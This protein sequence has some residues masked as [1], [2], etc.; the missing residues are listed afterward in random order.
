MKVAEFVNEFKNK[1]IMNT[2]I[3]EHAVSDYIENTLE[4]KTYIP[5][6]KKRKIIEVV[7]EQN[8][9]EIDGIKKNDSIN[10][11]LSFVISMLS[12]HTNIEFSEDPIADYDMLAESGLL[13]QIIAEFKESYDECDVL[14]KMELAS[15]LEDNNINVLVGRFLNGIL[16]KLD[17]FSG[18]LK[19]TFKDINVN[20]FLGKNFKDEDLAKLTSF[21]DRYNK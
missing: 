2:K 7:V 18:V 13:S 5:F 1:K 10:Q 21:L 3:N 6:M 16:N 14:L 15:K 9:K 19:D 11:Y 20:D 8:T 12:A 4:I 17:D